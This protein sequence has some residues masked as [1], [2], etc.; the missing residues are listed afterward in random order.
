MAGYFLNSPI[1]TRHDRVHTWF[2]WVNNPFLSC[3]WSL[4]FW[5]LNRYH[6][7]L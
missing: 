1:Y 2:I 5:I 6:R 7:I 4:K 3:R